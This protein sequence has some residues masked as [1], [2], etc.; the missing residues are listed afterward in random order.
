M[1]AINSI[2]SNEFSTENIEKFANAAKTELVKAD[3]KF[4]TIIRR[5]PIALAG[6]SFGLGV[7]AHQ[8]AKSALAKMKA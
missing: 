7:I 2:A 8:V 3:R 1:K 5:H 4:R 6:L